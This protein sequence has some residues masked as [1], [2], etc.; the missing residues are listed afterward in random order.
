M[1]YI[2]GGPV[3]TQ[4]IEQLVAS[5]P[6]SLAADQQTRLQAHVHAARSCCQRI[7]EVRRSLDGALAGGLGSAV[8]LAIE[9]DGLERVQERFDRRLSALVDE[10]R[11]AGA[12]GSYYDDGVPV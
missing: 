12:V 9:L 3:H 2:T 7:K 11:Q 5:V 6:E 4:R 10:L 1:I 8:D